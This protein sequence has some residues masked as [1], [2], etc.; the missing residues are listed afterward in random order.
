MDES[1]HHPLQGLRAASRFC[2]NRRASWPSSL[3]LR[4]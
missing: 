3:S 4:S 1:P 2:F